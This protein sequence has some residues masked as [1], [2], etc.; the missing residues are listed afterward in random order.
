MYGSNVE[1]MQPDSNAVTFERK[2]HQ[3]RTNA[4]HPRLDE[5]Q[6]KSN[7]QQRVNFVGNEQGN[8]TKDCRS[9][10]SN[11]EK[12]V[13]KN[14]QFQNTAGRNEIKSAEIGQD[15]WKQLKRVEI[16]KW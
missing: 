6:H 1:V 13:S 16:P 9:D 15:M 7:D 3:S 4:S 5:W 11:L 10:D 14:L 2:V 12:R 8:W